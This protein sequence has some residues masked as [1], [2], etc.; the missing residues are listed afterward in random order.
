MGE[1]KEKLTTLSVSG[2]PE[3]L[4]DEIDVIAAAE[5]RSRSNQTMLL[6]KEIVAIKKSIRPMEAAAR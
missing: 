6:L 3:S 1:K 4:I 2:I 5:R